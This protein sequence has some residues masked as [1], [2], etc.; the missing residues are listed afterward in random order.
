MLALSQTLLISLVDV[1]DSLAVQVF[2]PINSVGGLLSA[3]LLTMRFAHHKLFR[4]G[5]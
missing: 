2:S 4:R 3:V 5:K 1:E